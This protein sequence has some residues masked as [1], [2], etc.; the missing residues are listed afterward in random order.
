MFEEQVEILFKAFNNESFSHK[1]KYYTLPPEV[2][3][4][5][6]S[7][8]ELTLVPRPKNLPVECWQPVVSATDRGLDFMMKYGIKGIIGGGS[9][10][11]L[12]SSI[13]KFHEAHL[14]AGKES[15]HGTDLCLGIT[16]HLAD[17]KEQAIKEARPFYEEH[18]KMFGPLGFLGKLSPDQIEAIG[19]RGGIPDSGIPSLEDACENGAWYCGPSEGFVDF[20]HVLNERY[21]G[22][23]DV[24]VQSAMGTPEKIM[25]EQLEWF[26]KEVMPKIRMAE[27][28]D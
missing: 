17:T 6:Y 21:P 14:R 23:E 16:F 26:G 9:A 5:G 4:R 3:Y 19:R 27:A 1:G 12:N 22:L 2:P 11:L 25:V 13:T 24:N 18:A 15:Q 20:L 8:K 7:L 28:A 10:L